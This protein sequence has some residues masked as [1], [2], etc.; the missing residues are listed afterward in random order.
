MVGVNHVDDEE[1]MPA[2]LRA[3]NFVDAIEPGP[4]RRREWKAPKA[5]H[6]TPDL[7]LQ[8]FATTG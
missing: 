4:D 3:A 8:S 5:K 2:D 7:V 6:D 1:R